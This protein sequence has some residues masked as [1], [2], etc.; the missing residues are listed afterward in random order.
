MM[1]PLHYT[2]AVGLILF[3]ETMN[4][5]FRVSLIKRMNHYFL[6][7]T[8]FSVSRLI[9]LGISSFIVFNFY[10]FR[11]QYL[12]VD[13]LIISLIILDLFLWL[14][15]FLSHKISFLWKLHQ[16]HHSDEHLDFTSAF[17]FHPLELILSYFYKMLVVFVFG[18]S[19]SHFLMFEAIIPL[20]AMFNHSNIKLPAFLDKALSKIIITPNLHQVHHSDLNIEMNS[21]F[22][23]IFTFWDFISK[24]L[25]SYE[26]RNDNFRIG[27][28]N[29]DR[30]S[31][32]SFLNLFILPFKKN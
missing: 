31:S 16:V 26:A 29:I 12:K 2:L 6:N 19:L 5:I 20:F 18:I 13:H 10:D 28:K 15:H 4:P 24:K 11:S 23:T 3:F 8:Y 9:V 14:Q 30:K 32:R 7:L 17:R 22:G 21:N 27:L 25:I 1:L